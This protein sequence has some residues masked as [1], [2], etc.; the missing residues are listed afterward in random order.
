MS[1]T[2]DE[3]VVEM[4]FDNKQ[5]E[6]NVNTSI[7]TIDKLKQSLDLDGAG[8]GLEGIN[9]AAKKCD[10]ST[11]EKSVE[12]VKVKFSAL[13]VMAIT[14]LSNIT[15]SALNAGKRLASTFTVEPISTG[16]NE[17]ELKMGSIQTIMAGTG[18]SLDRVNQ[19][20]DE[21]NTYSDKTIYSF[22]DMTQNIGKFTNAGVK[23]DDAVAAIQGVANV[24]AVSGA[25]ANEAS[26]AMYNFGQ[27]LSAGYVKLIDW[28]SI[29]NA[30]MATVEFKQQLM[31]TAVEMGT[32]V[33]VGEKYQSTTTDLNGHV[34]EL[35]NSTLLFNDSLSSQWMTTEV[36]SKTLAKYADE[37][38]EIG[39]KAFAAAQDVKTFSQLMDTLKESAQSGWAESWQIMIGDFEEAKELFTEMSEFFGGLISNSAES[40]NSLL[41]GGF[42]SNWSKVKAEV[43][44]AGISLTEFQDKLIEVGKQ[45]GKI[46]DEM[47][48][49]A[50][51]FEK[52]LK[53]GWLTS[54]I[55]SEAIRSFIGD[56]SNFVEATGTMTNKLEE[57][58]EVVS[59]VING[60]FG[61]GADRVK[62][63]T[64]AGYDYAT[65]QDLVNKKLAG[66]EVQIEELSDTQLKNIGY[67]DEQIE[68]LRKLAEQAE[69]SGT[70]LNEL[71]QN[72]SKPSG[73]E[74]LIDSARNAL[75]GLVTAITAVHDAWTDI[76]PPLTGDQL[77]G[78][79]SLIH[80]FS[81]KL[82]MTEE[83]ADKLKR[84]FKGLFAIVDIFTTLTGGALKAA[85]KVAAKLLGM[86]DVDILDITANVGD[87]IVAFRD[88]IDQHNF[89]AKGIEK[90]LPYL[91]SGIKAFREWV[92]SLG[93]LPIV[94][95]AV[96]RF[97]DAFRDVSNRFGV[98]MQGG[99]ER[100]N[101]FIERV[102]AVDS[103]SLDNI[104]KILV[105]FRDNVL[106]YFLNFGGIFDK[107][108]QALKDF[109][110]DVRTAFD[111]V[112]GGADK[113]KAKMKTA[114]GSIIQFFLDMKNR[115]FEIALEIREKLA[116]KIGFGEIFAIGL[117]AAMVAFTKKI[118][119]ALST[120]AGPFEGIEKVLKSASN[121]L[122]AF[123]LETKSKALLN[124]AEAIAVLVGAL[125]VLTLLDQE[126]L[127][128]AI[129]VLGILAAGL[130]AVSFAMSK[131]G[132]PKD[133]IK[134]SVS[135]VAVGSSLL[136]LANAMK[137]LQSLDS[138]KTGGTLAVLGV[139]AVGLAAVSK[140]LSSK[141]KT[142]SSGALLMVSFALSLKILAGALKDLNDLDLDNMGQTVTLLIGIVGSL[143]LVAA[144]CKNVKFG[145]AATVLAIVVSLKLLVGCFKD[146]AKIDLG[147]AK[148][149]M[150]TFVAIFGMFGALMV[151]SKFAGENASKAGSAILKMSASLILITLA[152][153]MMSGIDP[154]DLDRAADT[155]TKLLLV[156]SAVTAAS[157]FAGKNAS[158]AGS[159]LLLMSGA[160]LILST[161]MVVLAH[162]DPSG[163]DRALGAITTLLLVF[164]AMMGIT[165][166]AK[167]SS[168]IQGTLITLTIAVSAMVAAVAALSL[169][170]PERLQGAT[171]AITSLV[172]VFSL[173]VASTHFA[174]KAGGTLVI[175]TGVVAGLAGILT[176]MSVF[177]VQNSIENAAGL[178]ILLT[179][180][181]AALLILSKMDAIA[182]AAYASIGVVTAVVAGLAIILGVMDG[183]GVTASI[184]SAASL[185]ILLTSMS[186]ALVILSKMGTIAPTAYAAI[187]IMTAV[188][189]GLAAILGIM[190]GLG[191]TASIETAASLSILLLSM[192]GACLILSGVGATGPAAFI[193]LGVL[194]TLIVGL[195]GIMAAI[196]ALTADN[197]TV[198]EDLDRAI[199]V[200]EKIGTGLGAVIGGIIGGAIGGLSSG[201]PIIGTNLAEFMTNAQPFFETVK[202][203]DSESMSGVKSLAEA[204]LI[205]TGT[206]ALE[207]LTSWFTGG[208]S[209]ADFGSQLEEL[210]T[211]M[212]KYAHI[213]GEEGVDF[214]AVE[215]SANAAKMLS[216]LANGLPNSGGFIA[217]VVGDNSI[218]DFGSQ[219]EGF[220]NAIVTYARIVSEEG[221][222]F[223]AVESS[224]NAAKMLSELENGLPNTGGVL[225]EWV[226]DNTL[227]GFG[228]QLEAFGNA[229]VTYA[230]IVSEEGVDFSAVE[231]SVNAATMLSELENGLPNTG[232]VLADWIGD[233]TLSG[234]GAQLEAFGN[235]I[236]AYARIVG[237][238]GVDFS[239]VEASVNAAKMLSELE[240]GLPNTGG[241]ISTW[242]GG[243][244][245]LGTFGS[246]VKLFGESLSDYSNSIANVK[247]G[248]VE[249]SANA[250]QALS[251]LAS[252][253]P[254]SSL[255]DQWFGG[256]QTLATFGN[257]IADFGEAMSD[258]YNEI[259]GID[260]PKM[261]GVVT[262][263]WNL[264]DLAK[265]V[266]DIDKNAFSNF[267]NSLS[268]LAATGI[269]GFTSAFY[270]CDS[271]VT[272]AVISMLNTVG[273]SIT[274][275]ASVPNSSMESVVTSLVNV[276]KTKTT[277]VGTATTSMMSTMSSKITSHTSSTKTAMGNVVSAA[278][279]KINAMKPEF[280][281]AGK[282]VGQGFV[283]GINSK[284]S[285]ASTAGR[286]L[287]LAAL[288][289]SK[290]ALDS[291]SPSREYIHLGEN[292]G[293]GLAI[294]VKNSIVPA[295]QAAS[296]MIDEVIAVSS[297]G[298]DA[299][300]EWAEEKK[301]YGELSLKDELAGYENLQKK[302][303]EG[304]QERKK[305]DREVY[306]LQNELV[307]STYQASI[308]WIEEEK[309]YNRLSTQ[310]ELEA[311]ERMQKRYLEGSEERKKI[312]REVYALRNQLVDESY[313]NSMDWIE[314]EKYYNRMTLTDELAAYKR[315]QSRYA[316]GTEE[317]EKMDREVY[318]VEKEIYEAQQQYIADVQSAQAAANQ[319]RAQLEQEYADK[320][321]SINEKLASDIKALNDQYENALKSREN[322]LYSSYG[323]F[324]EVKKRDE[325]SGET[326][327]KNLEGQVKEFGEWQ[328]ILD[329]LSARGLDSDL[330]SEL[331]DMGPSAIAEI[332]AL[333]S[334]S[335]SELEKYASLW[336]VKHAQAREQAVSELEGLRIETQNNIA[337]L[338]VEADR[339]LEAYRGVWQSKMDQINVDLNAELEQLRRDFAEKVGL[340][341]KDTDSEMQEMADT[342]QAIL[343]EAGWD[344]TGKQIVTGLTG[345]VESEKS[346]FLDALTQMALEGVQAVKDTLEINSPS[347][348]TRELGN[349]TGLGF[350]SGLK[351]YA[352][353]SY[354]AAAN[355]AES[356]K[357]GLSNAISMVAGVVDNEFDMQP[358]IRPVLDLTDVT[359]TA[360]ELDSLFYPQRTMGLVGQASLAFNSSM[361]KDG[362]TVNVN[363]EDVIQEL[364]SLRGEMAAMGE[365]MARMRV[366]L[367]TGVLVGEMADPMDAALGR[368]QAYRGRG[369]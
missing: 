137:T 278:V 340:I 7:S 339:E 194:A 243:S 360:G 97:G 88:W 163:L 91:E 279:S 212:V 273:S 189:A 341:K 354:A 207:S 134:M 45:H 183:L 78:A 106:G 87:A 175:M 265:G 105:D 303:V 342:A 289:A 135:I 12:S 159:M 29:E 335:D 191:V 186:A 353:K 349:Y 116:D 337:Q 164:G 315:V 312:D 235:A 286:N 33:K 15:N 85:I 192:S 127:K 90:A 233:N 6:A 46:T 13:E 67:T 263:V 260:I 193:G 319:R 242:F 56:A 184:E 20:L 64:D 30:N 143:A 170:D 34:S 72:L 264:V 306:R 104:G 332:K 40:R 331:Q 158:K 82:V 140:L 356:A 269:T 334:M 336:S 14:A 70:P 126:K 251:N 51:S 174:K 178:S 248:V 102:K 252:G 350:V 230:R 43:N 226:G 288:N 311:Y 77:Y 146:I 37:T 129:V 326:L 280:E 57:F 103:L 169:L 227:S 276:I 61:N 203:I 296:G 75:K 320:V 172:A 222:D 181:S 241:I 232:G 217:A 299:F 119:D 185:S 274:A 66:V 261:N 26:R 202:G 325:V 107:L 31:D 24:A 125:A 80:E 366:V 317:R 364:R 22:A 47:I 258:Y 101:A 138:D 4:R 330:I 173:L 49:E 253:L 358:M 41:R 11:L 38:T 323:L 307:S 8:K 329:S 197:P 122:N 150:G 224:V 308:D 16:F 145:A 139:L 110:S 220:G 223:S 121:A 322:S 84:T 249:A 42:S 9:D 352:G 141:E 215:A 73:R 155:V 300:A 109:G 99:I 310:E 309:Y 305:I 294:G 94:Q 52:S 365:Q 114:L 115:I 318:R 132:D 204:L 5:F 297:K 142:F 247:P 111:E 187:G 237:G 225:S 367:D 153:K 343:Q 271:E 74:L 229:I 50:G 298:I 221:V 148:S 245:D 165:Y 176:M 244:T 257:D 256:D 21:L 162:L 240:N 93:E 113:A 351:D 108:I 210:G 167:D 171:I 208:S 333:N 338:R 190:D 69:Q 238:D 58:D 130:M 259:S 218:S 347:R 151:A 290:K 55:F 179:S 166:F 239:A 344:E 302:Y 321:T 188:V 25:N 1:T 293:E 180:M 79:I 196:C 211:A 362:M 23:L 363:N 234:F 28:K 124:V 219:L 282:N 96:A 246:Q 213:V 314:R 100:I 292:I 266:K 83:T 118:S 313:Q 200:L 209:L 216:E 359:R 324:D 3:K 348:V 144:A 98:Y 275:N 136:L 272:S 149:N 154:L 283:N 95:K 236:V 368:K 304:S 71:I 355:M 17:Y 39:K 81:Q 32:L 182:P 168:K 262:A 284:L 195:G 120:I 152:F 27:A 214:S 76:F 112:T 199:M 44:E 147:K 357:D 270:N 63:L 301:Y 62:A 228:A 10:M 198:E 117:G 36:L 201:L 361:D 86:V 250:A 48:T 89:L 316:Q 92:A 327:M 123:A 291:H 53:S 65:I 285:S 268:S 255:F 59:R 128:G 160:I 345:G 161:T 281:T 328:D 206:S 277:D 267:S 131:M 231:A 35:F 133:L 346:N 177:N 205:L 54:D 254:S 2:I 60:D 19:K 295:S 18:E 156:F 157:H 369:I 287:G 68:T